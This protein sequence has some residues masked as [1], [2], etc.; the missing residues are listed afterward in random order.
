MG[1]SPALRSAGNPGG[2]G[3]YNTIDEPAGLGQGVSR[4]RRMGLNPK[5]HGAAEGFVPNFMMANPNPEA[6]ASVQEKAAKEN[7]AS[8]KTIS[9][10]GT[11]FLQASNKMMG[12]SMV[13]PQVAH[14]I[15][16]MSGAGP[17]GQAASGAFANVSTTFT[18]KSSIIF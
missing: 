6:A 5:T 3:V 11:S 2:V 17:R 16:V 1:S 9:K 13:L 7:K 10:A 14:A 8:A 12:L 4:A 15:T 18:A